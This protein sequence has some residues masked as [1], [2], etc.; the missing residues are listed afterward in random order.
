MTVGEQL[1]PHSWTTA[2]DAAGTE[3]GLDLDAI[4]C[5]SDWDPFEVLMFIAIPGW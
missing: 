1:V 3:V 5:D 4:R 2:Y